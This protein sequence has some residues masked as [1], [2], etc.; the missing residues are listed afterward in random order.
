MIDLNRKTTL[1]FSN[2]GLFTGGP[3][4][5]H[6]ETRTATYEIVFVV[7]GKAYIEEEG[8]RHELAEGDVLC[9]KPDA[10]HRGYKK[11]EC[12]FYW[13]HFFAQGYD[14][15]GI[16]RARVRDFSAA[17]VLFK[18]LNHLASLQTANA[19]IEC[20]IAAFL[21]Q[22]TQNGP[23]KS[24]LFTDVAEYIRINA[25]SAESVAKIARRFGYNA[26]YLSKLFAANSGLSL[27]KYIDKTRLDAVC[28]L[29]LSTTLTVKEIADRCGFESDNALLKFFKY[30][31]KKT[32]A[33]YRNAIC[34]SHTN[35]R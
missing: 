34:L 9:L 7:K 21:L 11:S 17:V 25:E 35:N 12:S 30:H 19:L 4:W 8:V 14:G 22:F 16:Y 26:D 28:S 13:L 5:I 18:Q 31:K 32:P 1:E 24:K 6:P 15:I 20:E 2:M 27:K 29:L 23:V 3:D 10:I 33:Q